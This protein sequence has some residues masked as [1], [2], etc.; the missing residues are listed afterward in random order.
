MEGTAFRHQAQT[1]S[2]AYKKGSNNVRQAQQQEHEEVLEG[3]GRRTLILAQRINQ[4][5]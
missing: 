3:G 4:D 2:H 5:I 1:K